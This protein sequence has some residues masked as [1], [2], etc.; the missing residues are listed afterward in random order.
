MCTAACYYYYLSLHATASTYTMYTVHWTYN[1][2]VL[3]NDEN[4]KCQKNYALHFTICTIVN[5]EVCSVYMYTVVEYCLG[6]KYM[7]L[8]CSTSLYMT[9]QINTVAQCTP[10][11]YTLIAYLYSYCAPI[12]L[13]CTYTLIEISKFCCP[14]L[15]LRLYSYLECDSNSVAAL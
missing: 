7:V 2:F 4:Y 13:L 15:L 14:I 3:N 8:L 10:N 6:I 12:L 9:G 11:T 1:E 5:K